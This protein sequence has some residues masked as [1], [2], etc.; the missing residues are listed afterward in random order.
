MRGNK[1]EICTRPTVAL[2]H[3]ITTSGLGRKVRKCEVT[4]V[5]TQKDDRRILHA[6]AQSR[7]ESIPYSEYMKIISKELKK[8]YDV[9]MARIHQLGPL[10]VPSS[11]N[12]TSR[13]TK[14]DI[15]PRHVFCDVC[16]GFKYRCKGSYHSLHRLL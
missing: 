8:P 3:P 16:S 2:P 10:N 7:D 11:N 9:V 5:F 6:Y 4:A 1:Q 15:R 12:T 13:V 14:N